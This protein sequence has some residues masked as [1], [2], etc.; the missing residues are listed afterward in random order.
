MSGS[1]VVAQANSTV[2]PLSDGRLIVANRANVVYL[3]GDGNA[4]PK[5]VGGTSVLT[6]EG[7]VDVAVDPLTG[8]VAV[9]TNAPDKPATID[10]YSPTGKRTA[11]YA[12]ANDEVASI[13]FRAGG[14]LVA[15]GWSLTAQGD[16]NAMLDDYRYDVRVVAFDANLAPL[17]SFGGGD[18]TATYS[19]EHTHSGGG[20]DFSRVDVDD[21]GRVYV[22]FYGTD[23]TY[24][25]G[26]EGRESL[27]VLRFTAD[28]VVDN[29]YGTNGVLTVMAF[30]YHGARDLNDFRV[31]DVRV[32][33]DGTV[34]ALT[35]NSWSPDDSN[36]SST[37]RLTRAQSNGTIKT[38]EV[39]EALGYAAAHPSIAIDETDD[40]HDVYVALRVT[41]TTTRVYRIAEIFGL[42]RV[43]PSYGSHGNLGNYVETTADLGETSVALDRDGKLLLGGVAGNALRLT[44]FAG[45]VESFSGKAASAQLLA[46]GTLVIKGTDKA[47]K[48]NA[49]RRSTISV[50][51]NG[52]KSFEFDPKAVRGV[53]IASG[54]GNDLVRT[55]PVA[56]ARS[57][58]VR[59]V[60][61]EAGTGNDTVL[62]SE[63][64]D[65][66]LGNGGNDRLEGSFG[67]D[68]LDGGDGND[69]LVGGDSGDRLF[70]GAGTDKLFVSQ[71]FAGNGPSKID[72]HAYDILSGGPGDDDARP[73]NT[74]SWDSDF[75]IS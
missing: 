28:G 58:N 46:D 44:R 30:D 10:L 14:G 51:I 65:T 21:G 53:F 4:D 57:M 23:W 66:V 19:F 35:H 75:V 3:R 2:T 36:G 43:D 11:S 72:D 49:T 15:L 56:G 40:G 20:V 6:L 68:F 32:A 18:A 1:Q 8:R 59:A 63:G 38:V 74:N 55:G 13:R 26:D 27:R 24:S 50:S 12:F 71:F 64:A 42:W 62:T 22:P 60:Y 52:G 9:L 73:D 45:T 47:D 41:G 67:V 34:Y 5:R 69:T 54:K 16:P 29:G 7:A 25:S 61:V 48:I 70:G 33:D 39:T 31:I 17:S 37:Y